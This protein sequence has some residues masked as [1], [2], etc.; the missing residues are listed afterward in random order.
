MENIAHLPMVKRKEDIFWGK[1]HIGSNAYARSLASTHT[2]TYMRGD[3]IVIYIYNITSTTAV[4]HDEIQL[5]QSCSP[6]YETYV[7]FRI[8]ITCSLYLLKLF[9]FLL[10]I[11]DI[12]KQWRVRNWAFR[13]KPIY[14]IIMTILVF[15]RTLI[16]DLWSKVKVQV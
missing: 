16:Y 4:A 12:W 14:P 8:C 13:P 3:S 6:W 15:R 9:L 2:H 7:Q 10:N 1:L 5:D 11:F